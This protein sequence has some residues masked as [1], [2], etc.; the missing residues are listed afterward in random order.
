MSNGYNT[1]G[2]KN[3]FPNYIMYFKSGKYRDLTHDEIIKQGVKD[4][5]I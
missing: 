3:Y 2:I 5:I 4:Q 1:S